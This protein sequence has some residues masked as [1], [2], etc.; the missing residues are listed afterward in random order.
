MRRE[1]VITFHDTHDA[2]AGESALSAESVPVRIMS[3]PA[4]LGDGCGVCLRVD[5]DNR[6]AAAAILRN[7]GISCE[8]FYI[9]ETR[10]GKSSYRQA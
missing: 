8:A 5:P 3:R 4:A 7:R 6:H 1:I 10:D 9:K 2:M